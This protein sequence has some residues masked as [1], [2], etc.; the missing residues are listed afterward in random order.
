MAV[1]RESTNVHG[2][3][4]SFPT[5]VNKRAIAVNEVLVA[6]VPDDAKQAEKAKKDMAAAAAKRIAP[7]PPPK[8]RGR[9]RGR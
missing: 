4:V 6:Y 7:T 1:K 5:Y 8:G 3:K 2:E 9:G